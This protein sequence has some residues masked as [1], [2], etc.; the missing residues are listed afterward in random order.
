MTCTINNIL[1]SLL[2]V[3]LTS[4]HFNE[5]NAAGNTDIDFFLDKARNASLPPM[6][7]L[8]FYD[9]VLV[10]MKPNRQMLEIYNEKVILCNSIHRPDL[11]ADTWNEA[12][13]HV[14]PEDIAERCLILASSAL[15]DR[16]AFRHRDMIEKVTTTL[17][18]DKPDSLRPYDVYAWLDLSAMF[19][20]L[21][22]DERSIFYINKAREEFESIRKSSVSDY[23]LN[24]MATHLIMARANVYIWQK[25]YKLAFDELKKT[26]KYRQ[27]GQLKE[28]VMFTHALLYSLTKQY[29]KADS[30]YSCLLAETESECGDLGANNYLEQLIIQRRI[31]DARRLIKNHAN[32]FERLKSTPYAKS[33]YANLSKLSRAEGNN[34]LALAY[35]DSLIALSD[36][37]TADRNYLYGLG[38]IDQ[39]EEMERCRKAESQARE[40]GLI[41][42]WISVLAGGLG[43]LAILST[44]LWLRL[45]KRNAEKRRLENSLDTIDDSHRH[46]MRLTINDLE[47][48]N[49][50]LTSATMRLVSISSGIEHIRQLA[51]DSSISRDEMSRSICDELKRMSLSEGVWERFSYYF[52]NVNTGFFEKLHARCPQLTNAERRMCAFIIMNLTNKEIASLTNRSVRTVECIKY[53]LRRKLG[54]DCSTEEFLVS[55][56]NA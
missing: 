54:I 42:V 27:S 45:R 56:N 28:N 48:K 43:L 30:L 22:N 50:Q 12:L 26:S 40:R 33:V 18:L 46:E 41:L 23:D 47:S 8:L 31:S 52:D 29:D 55:L 9:S 34:A 35:A 19:R 11:G 14:R 44:L 1:L 6:Q 20:A 15:A 2:F 17:S 5:A 16:R 4:L 10:E 25:K 38:I 21:D 24:R 37:L 32:S 39:I 13:L 49:R 7:R 36:S 3:A 53:N 51:L